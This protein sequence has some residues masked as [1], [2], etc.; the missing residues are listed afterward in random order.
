MRPPR[1]TCRL[2]HAAP[3]PEVVLPTNANA[4]A[5]QECAHHWMI[6]TPS[7]ESSQGICKHC[8]ST[9]RFFNSS[10]GRT[11]TRGGKPASTIAAAAPA[12]RMAED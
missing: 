6:E 9:R 4:A 5:Q 11:M 2:A 7:G 3:S 1:L 12:A 8:G 10:T